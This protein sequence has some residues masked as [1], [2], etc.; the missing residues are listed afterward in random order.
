M[1][2]RILRPQSI[3][4]IGA[5]R[6]PGTIGHETVASLIRCG[7]T[8]AL[9]PVNPD[10]RSICS[11]PAFPSVLDLPGPVDLAVVIVP[12][13]HVQPVVEQCAALGVGGIV[14]I[15][16]GFR[17]VGGDGI[18][19]ERVLTEFVRS[20]GIRMVGPN[21]MG[22]MNV[23]PAVSMNATFAPSMPPFGRAAFMSQ[24]GAMGLSVLDYAREYGIGISQFVSMGNKADVSGNDLLLAWENDPGVDTILMY[25]ENFGNPRK[26][27]EIAS[28]VSRTKSIIVVK[29]GR[30][31]SGARAASSHTGALAASDTAVDALLNQAGVLRAGTVEEL[32]DLA[33]VFAGTR[34]PRG[35]RVA[36]VTNAGGPG[37]LAA[38]ALETHGLDMVELSPE[39]VEAIRPLFPAEASVRNPLDMIAS[40][41]PAGYR[42]AMHALLNDPQVDA[43]VPIYIPPLRAQQKE[44]T[45]VIA[46]VA[47]AHPDKPVLPVLMG[48]EGL[49]AGRAEL[50]EAG[51]P[52]FIFPESAARG[53]AALCRWREWRDRPSPAVA[54]LTVDRDR[55]RAILDRHHSENPG[56]TKL[57]EDAVF[58]LLDAYGVTTIRRGI[59]RSAQEAA[60]IAE[61]LGG[62]V[63][64]KIL[65]HD[66]VH[67]T[68]V[69]GVALG[70]LGPQVR[71][72]FDTMYA[73][74]TRALP[75]ARLDGVMV[76]QMAAKGREMIVGV[77]REGSFGPL[78]MFGLGGTLVEALGDV[79]FRLAPVDAVEARSMV[80][81]IR[82]IR[83]LTGIRGDPPVDFEALE[84]AVRRIGQLA[85]DFPEIAELDVN[86]LLAYEDGILAVDGRVMVGSRE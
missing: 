55:A 34:R 78:V 12:K 83:L 42:V 50:H 67:K 35:R 38:D 57:P 44:T 40:A 3:A 8:G 54:P 14:I 9:Y 72:G 82:S 13:Q 52:G 62:P 70:L 11:V 23:D 60:A 69:G 51:L 46:E 31:R 84:D 22:V 79:V 17:E 58:D 45:R 61:E 66:I 20:R 33:M 15:S 7:F 71:E 1:L 39:T 74:V 10:A 32:F 48:L 53:L 85:W 4:V 65:S 21:C 56:V 63:A 64:L 29:S 25:V 5:S 59:A 43:V 36:V 49:P 16:A 24:S 77:T 75:D 41:T 28:R 47:L 68:D 86:P 80:H 81:G 30:S 73:A 26:F 27:L 18:E 2:N 6:R 76:Q 37:I 19:R